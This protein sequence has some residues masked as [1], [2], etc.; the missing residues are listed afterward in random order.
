MVSPS[1]AATSTLACAGGV[2]VTAKHLSTLLGEHQRNA[3]TNARADA[4]AVTTATLPSSRSPRC[5]GLAGRTTMGRVYIW[6]CMRSPGSLAVRSAVFL[7]QASHQRDHPQ[8]HQHLPLQTNCQR[9]GTA[10]V[11]LQPDNQ[12]GIDEHAK[13]QAGLK[14]PGAH[15]TA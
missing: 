2:Q 9:A 14:S 15:A 5:P 7:Q 10:Q 1:A 4:D 8:S 6:P 3:P 13:E 11:L 12:D